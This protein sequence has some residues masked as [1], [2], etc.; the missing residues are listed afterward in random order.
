MEGRQ[1][2]IKP[3]WITDATTVTALGDNVQELWGRL[4]AG[5]SGIKPVSRFPVDNYSTNIA[6][7]IEDLEISGDRSMVHSLIDRLFMS[8]GSVPQDCTVITAS[9]KAGI[10]NL[11]RLS[12]GVQADSRD[13]LPSGIPD[14]ISQRLGL[15]GEAINISAAC[16][17]STVA[18]AQ[19]ATLIASGRAETVFICCLDLVTEFIF[20]GFSS[21]QA[22]SPAPCQPFDKNRKG[23]TLGEGA[24]ALLLMS[25][26]KARKRGLTCLGTILGWSVSNDAFHITA[27]V[28]DGSGLIQAI[29]QA[30]NR[31]GLPMEKI[32][33]ICAHGT[34]TVY[35]DLMELVAF[36]EILGDNKIPIYS[37]KG[38]IGHTIGAAGGIEVALCLQSLACRIAPPTV[39]FYNPEKGAE[40]F[41]SSE[42]VSIEGDY[43]L[44]TSSGFGGVNAAIVLGKESVL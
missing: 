39:G 32:A 38:A 34:G 17:S 4:L 7:S 26:E 30:M 44:T 21:L 28:A 3:V 20:S 29:R 2:E 11:E 36:R 10:D 1:I 41:V 5:Q 43:M 27:P 19:G 42:P 18:V 13:I 14:I 22:L 9:T 25:G 35:N 37:V 6:A 31:S 24:A 12:R 23:L 8:V 40:G 15:N 33:A 16:A